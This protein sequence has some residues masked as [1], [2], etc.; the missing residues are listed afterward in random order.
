MDKDVHTF[1]NVIR[2]KVNIIARLEFEPAFFKA[3]VQHSSR[4]AIGTLYFNRSIW[5]I[6]GILI[7]ATTPVKGGP[8]CDSNERVSTQE[9]SPELKP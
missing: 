2:P 1:P 5:P 6:D 8:G 9:R 4:C 3:T 7:D